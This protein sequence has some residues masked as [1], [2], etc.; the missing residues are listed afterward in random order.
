ML[1]IQYEVDCK[2]AL[3]LKPANLTF[4]LPTM[5]HWINE[6]MNHSDEVW[7]WVNQKYGMSRIIQK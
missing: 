3:N 6:T 2:N 1:V 5:F 7:R 4:L